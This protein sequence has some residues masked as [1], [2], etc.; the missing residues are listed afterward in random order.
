[1][2]EETRH[3][4][5]ELTPT[6][7]EEEEMSLST[8]RRVEK[9][10]EDYKLEETERGRQ[11]SQLAMRLAI[12]ALLVLVM[13]FGYRKLHSSPQ[14]GPKRQVSTSLQEEMIV[15]VKKEEEPVTPFELERTIWYYADNAEEMR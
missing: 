10:E 6:L 14:H 8:D 13:L 15:E 4:L 7:P 5:P 1:M 11:M 9:K 2:R 3:G 12:L